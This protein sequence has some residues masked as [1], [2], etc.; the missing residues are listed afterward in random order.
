MLPFTR[1][2][3]IVPTLSQL[4]PSRP[5]AQCNSSRPRAAHVD[6]VFVQQLFGRDLALFWRLEE[7]SSQTVYLFALAAGL[8]LA[9]AC[10]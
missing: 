7:P 9:I 4:S 2:D 5:R 6:E 1:R 10:T 3:Y 8:R